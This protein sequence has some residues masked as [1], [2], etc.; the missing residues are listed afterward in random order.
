MGIE[1]HIVTVEEHLLKE[2]RHILISAFGQTGHCSSIKRDGDK[3]R[4]Q[5]WACVGDRHAHMMKAFVE[6]YLEHRRI[7]EQQVRHVFQLV[8]NFGIAADA[9]KENSNM[10]YQLFKH[11]IPEEV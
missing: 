9:L 6:G 2:V 5:L 1:V 4:M 10:L 8:A 3:S 11:Y 7:T